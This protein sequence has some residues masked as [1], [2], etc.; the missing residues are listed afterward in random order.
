MQTT[1]QLLYQLKN[2]DDPDAA[3]MLQMLEMGS[4]FSRPHQPE[5]CFESPAREKL[6]TLA[7][8]LGAMNFE[9]ELYTPDDDHP[10]FQ[11]IARKEMLLELSDMQEW[12]KKFESLSTQYGV[13]YDG[14]GAEI[15]A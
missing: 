5:F 11:L 13:N 9:L 8:V 12:T 3:L 14:W 1:E 6:E 7:A 4:D 15:N 10:D 2:S